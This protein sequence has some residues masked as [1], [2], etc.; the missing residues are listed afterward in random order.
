MNLVFRFSKPSSNSTFLQ[1]GH[2]SP[3]SCTKEKQ[4]FKCQ[5][6]WGIFLIQVTTSMSCKQGSLNCNTFWNISDLHAS[7]PSFC[8]FIQRGYFWLLQCITVFRVL[9]SLWFQSFH[10]FYV[11][12]FLTLNSNQ[13]LAIQWIS[14]IVEKGLILQRHHLNHFRSIL[15][16]W[17]V[18]EF[19]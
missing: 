19:P 15:A 13:C 16:E 4:V 14:I 2:T 10:I 11:S 1:Q 8:M 9:A 3:K 12:V 5:R 7:Q 17:G 6:T 18:S